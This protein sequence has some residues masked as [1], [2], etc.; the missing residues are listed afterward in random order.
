MHLHYAMLASTANFPSL[1]FDWVGIGTWGVFTKT[2]KEAR[3]RALVGR[4]SLFSVGLD[5][6]ESVA[7]R[8]HFGGASSG[9]PLG[10]SLGGTMPPPTHTHLKLNAPRGQ[11]CPPRRARAA[12]AD[13]DDAS[14]GFRRAGVPDTASHGAQARPSARRPR[15]QGLC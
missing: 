12:A 9:E 6:G 13:D 2:L 10:I 4:N 15:A 7:A 5:P 3:R 11:P 14:S 1:R 8:R